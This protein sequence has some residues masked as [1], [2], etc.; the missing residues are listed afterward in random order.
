M[1]NYQ[2][3]DADYP[4]FEVYSNNLELLSQI[5]FSNSS[6]DEIYNTFHDLALTIPMLGAKL[7]SENG[8]NGHKLYRARLSKTISK[9]EDISLIQTFSFPP[10]SVC[11]SNQRA[12]LKYKSVFYCADEPFPAIKECGVEDNDEGYLSLWE[13]NA[14]RDLNYVNCFQEE[15]PANN[16]WREYGNYHHNFLIEKQTEENIEL[17]KHKIALRN[18]VTHKFTKEE[19]PY[20]ISSMLANEYLYENQ[21]D[22]IMYPSAK[23]FQEYTNFAIHPNVVLKHLKCNKIL[24][25]KVVKLETEQ[26]QLKFISIGHIEN[27]RINWKKPTDED[28]SDLGFKKI[29]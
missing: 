22:L 13:I 1:D 27:D 24:K 18:L 16:Y 11:K 15:L 29:N 2:T 4:D 26:V 3:I 20:F 28:A 9:D 7:I 17:L 14:T 5:D 6:Y 23:T 12:N 25:F 21:S 19:P 10:T 8:I